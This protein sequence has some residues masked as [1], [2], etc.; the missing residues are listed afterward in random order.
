MRI[1]NSKSVKNRGVRGKGTEA[2]S[3]EQLVE[4]WGQ[5]ATQGY[6]SMDNGAPNSLQSVKQRPTGTLGEQHR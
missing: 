6:G 1:V 5:S 4:D 2:M 3:N